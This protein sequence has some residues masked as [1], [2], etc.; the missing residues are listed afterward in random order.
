M[1]KETI[2]GK[3]IFAKKQATKGDEASVQC[4]PN[5]KYLL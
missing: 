4:C 3:E 5:P 1:Q 2:R